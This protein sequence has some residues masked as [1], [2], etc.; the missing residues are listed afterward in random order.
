MKKTC[1]TYVENGKTYK[2]DSNSF[3]MYINRKKA[4]GQKAGRKITQTAIREELADVAFVS[5]EAVKN[6]MYGNNAPS[7]I[8]QVKVIAEYFDVDYHEL[9][10]KEEEKA[11]TM[12]A[13]NGFGKNSTFQQEYTKN[14]IRNI[15]HKML[16]LID[17]INYYECIDHSPES[18]KSEEIANMLR[19]GSADMQG[20][21]V[22]LED[23][24]HRGMLDIPAT[25][26]DKINSYIL[27]RL[28]TCVEAAAPAF[29]LDSSE[30]SIE[31]YLEENDWV[32]DY[33]DDN[34]WDD[35]RDI[36]SEFIVEG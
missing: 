25:T 20:S 2:F 3:M 17:E 21:L 27:G 18:F 6:W 16:T 29:L 13:E 28:T 5:Q 9:L 14:L 34:Y 30:E 26:Y 10:T 12:A 8:E 22:E 11:M 36:F 33:M 23:M 4:R 35:L 7:D 32:F 19:K 1:K 15:Y 31:K 24:L